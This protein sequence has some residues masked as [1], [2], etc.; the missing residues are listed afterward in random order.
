MNVGYMKKIMPVPSLYC[1]QKWNPNKHYCSRCT[2]TPKMT[3]ELNRIKCM[4]QYM[5]KDYEVSGL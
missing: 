3:Q 1:P 2:P 5:I 4:F